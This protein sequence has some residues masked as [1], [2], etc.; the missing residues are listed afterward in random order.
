MIIVLGAKGEKM[1]LIKIGFMLLAFAGF[2]DMI[3]GIIEA[4]EEMRNGR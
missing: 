1:K 3:I 2:L 4:I